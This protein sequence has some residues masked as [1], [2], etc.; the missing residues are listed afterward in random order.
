MRVDRYDPHY[1]P[2][3]PR[4]KYD[5]ILCT[6]V[7]NTVSLHQQRKILDQLRGLLH[8]NG[9][10]YLTVRRDVGETDSQRIVRMR[11]PVVEETS[12]YC[13]YVL[14]GS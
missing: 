6:Y 8:P 1:A 4:G 13:I 2:D 11:L 3:Y 5:T 12:S 10:A 7:L 9:K 14:A